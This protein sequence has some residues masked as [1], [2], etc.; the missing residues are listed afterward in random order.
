MVNRQFEGLLDPRARV[1]RGEVFRY[2]LAAEVARAVRY[3]NFL[4]V[5]ILT[6]SDRPVVLWERADPVL[7]LVVRVLGERLRTTDPMGVLPVGLGLILLHVAE[8]P[9]R[10]VAERLVGHLANL[11]VV[12]RRLEFGGGTVAGACFP[13]DGNTDADLLACAARRLGRARGREGVFF[14]GAGE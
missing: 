2:L 7:R 6:V 4:T 8:Q 1:L 9:A 12:R 13:R 10:A 14:G 11:A 3:R 5:C